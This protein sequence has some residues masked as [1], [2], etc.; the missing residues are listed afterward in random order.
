MDV[1]ADHLVAAIHIESGDALLLWVGA[2]AVANAQGDLHGTSAQRIIRSGKAVIARDR[3]EGAI[4]NS[5]T[6]DSSSHFSPA[7]KRRPLRRAAAFL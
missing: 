4:G 1:P 7:P 5:Q 6:R 3:L 2:G